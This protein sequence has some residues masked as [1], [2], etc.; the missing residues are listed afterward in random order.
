MNL[1]QK[2]IS[3][4][5]RY[6]D[7][8]PKVFIK[9]WSTGPFHEKYEKEICATNRQTDRQTNIKKNYNVFVL[10]LKYLYFD[11]KILIGIRI[12]DLQTF[13]QQHDNHLEDKCTTVI[14]FIIIRYFLHSCVLQIV[15]WVV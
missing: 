2:Q 12:G 7:A 11:L 14:F 9:Y 6:I 3:Q 13:E 5:I 4:P 10:V 1:L 8:S 15:S